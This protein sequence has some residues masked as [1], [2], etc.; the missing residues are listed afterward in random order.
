MRLVPYYRVKY[1][2]VFY[3]AGEG[4]SINDEDVEEMR[5]HGV[6][7]ENKSR[8]ASP[9]TASEPKKPGRPRKAVT[10]HDEGQPVKA[11]TQD[12]RD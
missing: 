12:A 3:E 4:F 8:A 5:Q 2:G 9:A 7:Y 11:E 1:N 6:L 10:A